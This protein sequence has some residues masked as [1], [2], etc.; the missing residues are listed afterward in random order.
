MSTEITET[1]INVLKN[2]VSKYLSIDDKIKKLTLELKEAKKEKLLMSN[3]V[4]NLMSDYN[5]EDLNT[6]SGKLKYTISKTKKAVSKKDLLQK[7]SI[8]LKSS[9][10]A[11][12]A[13]KFIYDNREVV[14]KVRLKRL[15]PRKKKN[16]DL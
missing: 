11:N 9:D 5:I 7:L 8:F 13:M 2:K 16:V 15:M 12:D 10:K 14:E 1:E 3:D 4:L 6:K